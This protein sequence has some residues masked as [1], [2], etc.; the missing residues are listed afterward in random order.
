MLYSIPPPSTLIDGELLVGQ[1]TNI[2]FNL[3]SMNS[4]PKV[5]IPVSDNQ[6][7]YSSHFRGSVKVVKVGILN[8]Q[9]SHQR[10]PE[11]LLQEFEEE[12]SQSNVTE[13]SRGVNR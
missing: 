7:C 3:S 9:T 5:L 4:V 11:R 1:E 13:Q 12:M 2:H 8:K 6:K 10:G